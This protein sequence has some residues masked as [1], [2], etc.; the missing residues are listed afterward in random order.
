M[1]KKN[2][3]PGLSD[4]SKRIKKYKKDDKKE[5]DEKLVKLDSLGGKGKN[6]SN[7]NYS[8]SLLIRANNFHPEIILTCLSPT[9]IPP[10]KFL[11]FLI[12]FNPLF[13]F[14]S[15]FKLKMLQKNKNLPIFNLGILIDF[16]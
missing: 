12:I 1:P 6:N 9:P 7:K 13:K 4:D 5:S 16:L 14:K 15:G 2:Y 11:I 3:K 8:F 10:P